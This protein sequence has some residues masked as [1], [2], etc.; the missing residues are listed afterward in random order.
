MYLTKAING[1]EELIFNYTFE[2]AAKHQAIDL[3]YEG[4]K[5]YVYFGDKHIGYK[6]LYQSDRFGNCFAVIPC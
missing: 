5:T 1:N 6:K 4:Y 2:H 3:A